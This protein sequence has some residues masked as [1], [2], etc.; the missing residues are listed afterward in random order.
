LRVVYKTAFTPLTSESES[1]ETN[2]GLPLSCEDIIV[3][4]T[5]IRMI[6]PRETKRSFSES[7]GD[8]RRPEEIPVGGVSGTLTNLRALKRDRIQAEAAKL[9]RQYP[10]FISR[11]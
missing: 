7:Q 3:L 1:F 8:T 9:T 11:V 2:A 10:T 6:A 4:G 5:Q